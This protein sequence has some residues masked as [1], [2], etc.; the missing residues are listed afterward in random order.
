M[1][2]IFANYRSWSPN[3]RLLV[4]KLRVIAG[5]NVEIPLSCC[6]DVE[7]LVVALDDPMDNPWT[8]I[9]TLFSVL[10]WV[11]LPIL[12][13]CGN[14][15]T[16][17]LSTYVLWFCRAFQVRERPTCRRGASL[18]RI[19]PISWHTILRPLWL[20][21]PIGCTGRYGVVGN[22]HCFQLIGSWISW[23]NLRIMLRITTNSL[24]SGFT[25]ALEDTKRQ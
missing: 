4:L 3:S 22:A 19:N 1:F 16:G 5:Y 9:S 17:E 10:H 23:L 6:S 8:T 18:S 21:I 2:L 24:P 20:H 25:W 11:S 15:T 12:M 7:E 14:L 13:S